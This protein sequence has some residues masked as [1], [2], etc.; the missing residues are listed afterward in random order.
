MRYQLSRAI[1]VAPLLLAISGAANKGVAQ[2]S[3]RSSPDTPRVAKYRL[4]VLGVFDQASGEPVEGAEVFD[5]STGWSAKTTRTGT[6]SLFFLPDGGGLVRIRKVGYQP[7]VTVI[8][9]SPKDTAAVTLLL[10]RAIELPKVVVTDSSRRFISTNLAGFEERR[11]ANLG[12][13]FISDSVLRAAE[14]RAMANVLITMPGLTF[15]HGHLV[16]TRA[17]SKGPVLLS[18]PSPGLSCSV[19]VYLDGLRLTTPP[20]FKRESTDIYV[21]VEFYASSLTAPGWVSASDSQC[22]VL[23]LWTRER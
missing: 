17:A 1:Q 9:I 5:I 23:L 15:S 8:A 14:G 22:G 13:H 10:V 7:L 20:D 11:R 4:R 21:G 12:G 3:T 18:P 6:V 16:S 19:S 2:D